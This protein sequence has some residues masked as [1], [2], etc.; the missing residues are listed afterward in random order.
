[1]SA[2][3]GLFGGIVG[4]MLAMLGQWINNRLASRGRFTELLVVQCSQLI[5]L[6]EDYRNRVW[7]ERSGLSTDAVALWDL[8]GYRVAEAHLQILSEDNMILSAVGDL[9]RTGTALGKAWRLRA[10]GDV[11]ESAW[12]AHGRALDGF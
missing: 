12:L 5:A 7:E 2:W 10:D 9:K 11:V 4:A 8:A 3:V 6:S 1:M